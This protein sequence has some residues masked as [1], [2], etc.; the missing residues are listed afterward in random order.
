MDAGI[1]REWKKSIDSDEL[2]SYTFAVEKLGEGVKKLV[3]K[4][5]IRRF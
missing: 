4:S 5:D 3:T 1:R 2:M